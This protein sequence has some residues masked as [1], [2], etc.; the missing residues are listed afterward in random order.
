MGGV[1]LWFHLFL[2]SAPN[3]E[4]GASCTGP[5]TPAERGSGMRR[6]GGWNGPTDGLSVFIKTKISAPIKK[7]ITILRT[8]IP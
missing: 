6:N 1:K 7:G 5:I 4:Q 2:T 8:S 3:G